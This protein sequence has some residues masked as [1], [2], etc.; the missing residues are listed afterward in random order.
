M[1]DKE[2]IEDNADTDGDDNSEEMSSSLLV[3]K[4]LVPEKGCKNIY[5]YTHQSSSGCLSRRMLSKTLSLI[6]LLIIKLLSIKPNIPSSVGP[7]IPL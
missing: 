4:T 3:E 2:G 5:S 1:H 6:R 7:V